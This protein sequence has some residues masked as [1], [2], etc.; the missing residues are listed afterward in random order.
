MPLYYSLL[1]NSKNYMIFWKA[2]RW[3]SIYTDDIRWGSPFL[4]FTFLLLHPI[5]F[6][7]TNFICIFKSI[8]LFVMLNYFSNLKKKK[9]FIISSDDPRP[10]RWY[11]LQQNKKNNDVHTYAKA[12]HTLLL[13]I[14]HI[15]YNGR[16]KTKWLAMALVNYWP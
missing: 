13:F 16:I 3:S 1:Y 2:N 10:I 12:K 8:F 5:M 11:I 6:N 4:R 7:K 14:D 15:P 9:N